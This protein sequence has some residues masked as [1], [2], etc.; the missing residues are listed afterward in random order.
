MYNFSY[1]LILV[2]AMLLFFIFINSY[3]DQIEP[4]FLLQP[5]VMFMHPW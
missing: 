2:F 1:E 3:V 4:I 5:Y